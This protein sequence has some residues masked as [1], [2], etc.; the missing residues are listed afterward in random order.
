M[1]ETDKTLLYGGE[2]EIE[3]NP[4]SHRYKI[5][6]RGKEIGHVPSITTI[7][8]VLDKP[9]LIPWAAERAVD[10]C[11][12]AI[13]PDTP[14]PELYLEEVFNAAKSAHREIKERAG[15]I[16]RAVHK[17]I[18]DDVRDPLLGTEIPEEQR[19]YVQ[20]ASN[21]RGSHAL[22]IKFSE[23]RV[24]SRR[25]RISGTTD[26]CANVDGFQS[27]ID[28]KTSKGLYPS[29]WLQLSAYA[30]FLEEELGT[31]IQ[32]TYLVHLKQDGTFEEFF[33]NRA[34]VS[35]DFKAFRGAHNLYKRV[36]ELNRKAS[37]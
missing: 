33:H 30:K 35:D 2:V 12:Q 13:A 19:G 17:A 11:R 20:A 22:D 28:W 37:K 1:T 16:G 23:R 10:V 9:F 24:Y 18:E 8:N 36:L 27:V 25:C 32:R 7:C 15:D 26:T 29:Y 6:D 21:W 3:F 5:T 31:K 14:Y 4:R 34:Q